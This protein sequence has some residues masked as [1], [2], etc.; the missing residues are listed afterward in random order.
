M[1]RRLA[2]ALAD[3]G[4]EEDLHLTVKYGQTTTDPDEVRELVAGHGA[5][6]VK[7][8]DTWGDPLASGLYYV[9]VTTIQGRSGAKLMLLR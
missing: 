5:V 7:L 4:R 3:E 2:L 1:T 6:K 8:T 9:V